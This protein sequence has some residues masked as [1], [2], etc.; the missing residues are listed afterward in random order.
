MCIILGSSAPSV[1]PSS[2]TTDRK[3]QPLISAT[4]RSLGYNFTQF[5]NHLRHK[6]QLVASASLS[7]LISKLRAECSANLIPFLC[8]L[9]FPPCVLPKSSSISPCGS[10]CETVQKD[11]AKIGRLGFRWP[12]YLA[13]D[14][15]PR[16]TNAVKCFMRSTKP[17]NKTIALRELRSKTRASSLL[18]T[19]MPTAKEEKPDIKH[20]TT[21]PAMAQ[22]LIRMTRKIID[23]SIEV[24]SEKMNVSTPQVKKGANK[25]IEINVATSTRNPTSKVYASN[26]AITSVGRQMLYTSVPSLRTIVV[27]QLI[28]VK[29]GKLS[30]LKRTKTAQATTTGKQPLTADSARETKRSTSP[31]SPTRQTKTPLYNISTSHIVWNKE[32]ML[33]YSY[34]FIVPTSPQRYN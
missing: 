20:D 3:C 32:G 16:V 30:G 1:I 11:C 33:C 6:T 22:R 13:C 23:T 8:Q 28:S 19:T 26:R 7:K 17:T 31:T 2:T 14:Q 24:S 18:V 15:F 4:C 34:C 9:Y 10:L 25:P 12:G 27:E 29:S 5:P 21:Y